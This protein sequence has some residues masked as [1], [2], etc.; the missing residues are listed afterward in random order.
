MSRRIC[1][2][3]GQEYTRARHKL[4]PGRRTR[5]T[6]AV[7]ARFSR[8]GDGGGGCFIRAVRLSSL[9]LFRLLS[10]PRGG[11]AGGRRGALR[12]PLARG[13]GG[14]RLFGRV[15]FAVGGGGGEDFALRLQPVLELTPGAAAAELVKLVS[16]L[17]DDASQ[18]CRVVSVYHL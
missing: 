7:V 14:D 17:G 10:P 8:S 5:K 2:V 1:F 12:R 3:A 11:G 6:A 15:G 18:V 16:A 4:V 9:L 13:L